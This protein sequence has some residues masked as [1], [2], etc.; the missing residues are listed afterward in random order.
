LGT[1]LLQGITKASLQ[2]RS[3]ISA[4]SFQGDDTRADRSRIQRQGRQAHRLEE[5]VIVG[6]L[7]PAEHGRLRH[8][9]KQL[10]AERDLAALAA[11][12]SNTPCS[13]MA[14]ER[15]YNRCVEDGR[16][17]RGD[18]KVREAASGCRLGF[19]LKQ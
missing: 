10:A 7:I 9:L 12:S 1:P 11:N 17:G 14:A 15:D 19:F 4:A 6:R 13:P 18:R 3:F 8:K 2:T 5:N 16:K